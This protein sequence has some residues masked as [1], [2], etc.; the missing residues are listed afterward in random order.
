MRR[1]LVNLVWWL[2]RCLLG[3]SVIMSN[4]F[5][6]GKSI[7]ARQIATDRGMLAY[8]AA[9]STSAGAPAHLDVG[10]VGIDF[11]LFIVLIRVV[12]E[13]LLVTLWIRKRL[14]H[15]ANFPP[16]VFNVASVL[17]LLG[18]VIRQSYHA[19]IRNINVM[20]LV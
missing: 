17:R 13:P 12:G 10:Q 11:C 5:W 14:F 8:R 19:W 16:C 20:N 18:F 2:G 9:R 6:S 3:A 4:S 15:F 7:I 1:Y